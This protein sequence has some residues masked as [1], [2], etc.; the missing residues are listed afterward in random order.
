MLLDNQLSQP[1]TDR[2]KKNPSQGTIETQFETLSKT[3]EVLDDT[4][5]KVLE[6]SRPILRVTENRADE[7]RPIT[8]SDIPIANLLMEQ[9]RRLES[10][11]E[12]LDRFTNDCGL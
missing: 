7:T 10:I 9:I 11:I 8:S 4:S 12:R 2:P 1:A 6:I 5:N 3:I